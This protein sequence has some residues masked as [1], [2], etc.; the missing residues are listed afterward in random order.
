MLIVTQRRRWFGRHTLGITTVV[1]FLP[2]VLLGAYASFYASAAATPGHATVWTR[3]G[4]LGYDNLLII[5]GLALLFIQI[6]LQN[7]RAKI[8]RGGEQAKNMLVAK[9]LLELTVRLLALKHPKVRYRALVTVV[10]TDGASRRT[11]TGY[12][13]G[14]DPEL[15]MAVPVDFGISGQAFSRRAAAVGDVTDMDADNDML[16]KHGTTGMIWPEM[17]S[18]LA[19]PLLTKDLSESFGTV[20]FDADALSSV[21]YLSDRT[22]KELLCLAAELVNS[23]M[24][25]YSPD[26]TV[27]DPF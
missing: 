5:G 26:G 8:E 12:N 21:S 23:L 14:S 16:H 1:S 24:R 27:R 25:G 22:T 2:P 17:R 3:I 4:S 9:R 20:N 11:V 10:S 6:A 13:I 7:L 18:V 19:V 15:A